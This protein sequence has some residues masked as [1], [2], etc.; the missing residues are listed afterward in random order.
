LLNAF[1]MSCRTKRRA[2]C[3]SRCGWHDG[4]YVF[5][6]ATLKKDSPGACFPSGQTGQTGQRHE[7]N[8]LCL[9][10]SENRHSGIPDKLDKP[11]ETIVLQGTLSH[12]PFTTSGNLEGWRQTVG[13]LARGNSRLAFA[14]CASLAGALLEPSGMESGGFNLIGGS[15]VGKTTTL[16]AAGSVWGKGSSAGG[17]VLNWRATANGLEGLAALHSDAALC[18][19]ELG[20]IN[21][22]VAESVAYMLGGGTGKIRASTDGNARIVRNWRVMVLSTGEMS[23]ADK[24]REANGTVRTGQLVRL[25]D[26]PADAGMGFGLFENLHGYGTAQA[27]ADAVK[28][29]AAVSHGHAAREFISAFLRPA[30]GVNHDRTGEDAQGH[31]GPHGTGFFH[32]PEQ[33]GQDIGGTATRSGGARPEPEPLT[34]GS[35]PDQHRFASLDAALARLGRIV[36]ELG[37]AL[38]ALEQA[39]EQRMTERAQE[40][41]RG[42]GLR[43]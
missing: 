18:L 28:N 39:V 36:R 23:L 40:R 25:V 1:F 33:P 10:G 12:N 24:I 32:Q 30:T 9:P 20:Q 15:S 8:G 3:V 13:R 43:M 6:D 19:D 38:V 7:D 41:S 4:V 17:Y 34:G 26:I 11:E 29:A 16:V 37:T 27:F 35:Q 2:L 5:P 31:P 14:V 42:P 21:G 22:Q